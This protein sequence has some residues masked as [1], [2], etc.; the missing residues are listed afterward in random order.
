MVGT[1]KGRMAEC[2]P[3]RRHMAKGLCASCYQTQYAR[4]HAD[5]PDKP[6]LNAKRPEYYKRW[7]DKHPGRSHRRAAG[8]NQEQLEA[9]L[10][11]Q[12]GVC[13]VCG[14]GA[15]GN[16]KWQVDHDHRSGG[17]RAILCGNCNA[18]LGCFDDDIESLQ[19]AIAYL[20]YWQ[21]NPGEPVEI[22]PK[23]K[24][25]ARSKP[26]RINECGHPERDHYGHGKCRQCYARDRYREALK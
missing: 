21:S 3:D 26:A 20:E 18:G 4:E 10:A 17:V 9:M 8:I 15:N 24:G 2:H 1:F 11:K 19:R 23:P 12:G 22:R 13:A 7:Y 6:Y 16:G 5:D 14:H 25:R